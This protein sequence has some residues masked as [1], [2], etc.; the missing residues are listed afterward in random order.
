MTD[1][2]R[3]APEGETPVNPYSL[4]EA[5]NHSSDT[6]HTAW[7]IFLAVMTYF[8]IAVTGV[9]HR[10]L[11]IETPV[12]LPIL[13]VAIPITQFFQF[14]PVVLVLMHVGVLSQ[15]VLLARKTLEFDH[16][17][18]LLE[19]TDRRTHP[20]RL[21]LNNFFFVQ[22]VAG[23]H[24][25]PVMSVFLH[26]MSWLTLVVLPVLLLLYIQV[27]FLPYH[28]QLITWAHRIALIIDITFLLLI[29][30]FLMRL[31]TSFLRALWR[32]TATNP[33]SFLITLVVLGL[34]AIF[35]IFVATIPG[36]PLDRISTRLLGTPGHIAERDLR[37]S[38]GVLPNLFSYKSNGALFG[39]VPRWLVVT[40]TDL[41]PDKDIQGDEA[42][43]KLRGR[44]LRYA[45]L[46]RSDLQ[47]ADFTG[48]ILDDA[49]LVNTNLSKSGMGCAVLGDLRL[50]QDR[51]E[52]KCTSARRANFTGAR[53]TGAALTGAD[54]RNAK[55]SE[56][57]LEGADLRD[58]L[59][60]GTNFQLA[61]LEK[62]DMSG[63][64]RA[65]GANFLLANLQGVDLNG[66]LLQNATLSNAS[67]QGAVLSLAQL[68]GA[69]LRDAEL[70][71]A[72]LAY[73]HLEG[74]DLSGARIVG[75]DFR[76]AHVWM[77][78]PPLPD[79][80]G[81]ADFS[82]LVMKPLDEDKA[83]S[84]TRMVS[85]IQDRRLGG[86]IADALQPILAIGDS[87]AW[88][89][90]PEQQRW[91]SLVNG[92]SGALAD[93]YRAR[94]T[95]FL[96]TTACSRKWANGAVAT[97]IARRAMAQTFR[98]DAGALYD[99]IKADTCPASKEI[100]P[101]VLKDLGSYVDASHGN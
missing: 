28:S 56:G 45:R 35:S 95:D 77:T 34:A 11:L 9:T 93:S 96:G 72:T 29:G 44:N 74:A 99:R 31:E 55:L 49:S 5:V 90:G 21:E 98:G 8:M 61:R 18:R 43:L 62:A 47:Q 67:L 30:V 2:S 69:V 19:T 87:R 22:A 41:V 70:D 46:D 38:S 12:A 100:A 60:A 63:G 97:G 66:A 83:A 6:V 42:T 81:L 32:T 86:D 40:D 48:A 4:L 23:P 7:L 89:P 13:Q 58:A 94:V 37:Y 54:L 75:A 57:N 51:I 59:L 3:M 17:I 14:A 10:D 25:S 80:S 71:G 20:L 78:K 88:A 101:K 68:Q 91:Q 1:V 27:V 33:I 79:T 64:V 39:V 53:M 24:R 52:A 36:E 16:A 82:E 73:A 92:A 50:S 65:Q 84:L 15:V 26:G 85:R 76:G